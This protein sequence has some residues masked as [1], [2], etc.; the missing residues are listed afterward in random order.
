[1]EVGWAYKDTKK[2]WWDKQEEK[3]QSCVIILHLLGDY[4]T[5]I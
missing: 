5:D 4:F 3:N 2:E 1:M